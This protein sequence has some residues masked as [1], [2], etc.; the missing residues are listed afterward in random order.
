MG[1]CKHSITSEAQFSSNWDRIRLLPPLLLDIGYHLFSKLHIQRLKCI[2]R[3]LNRLS[4]KLLNSLELLHCTYQFC[5]NGILLFPY[6]YSGIRDPK[7]TMAVILTIKPAFYGHR[8]LDCPVSEQA[9]VSNNQRYDASVI[10]FSVPAFPG[11]IMVNINW[12]PWSRLDSV[13]KERKMLIQLETSYLFDQ[14]SPCQSCGGDE[15]P[16][17]LPCAELC[18]RLTETYLV[19]EK[20]ISVQHHQESQRAMYLVAKV[21]MSCELGLIHID[22]S[23]CHV[24]AAAPGVHHSQAI[25]M[26]IL[27]LTLVLTQTNGNLLNNLLCELGQLCREPE[28]AKCYFDESFVVPSLLISLVFSFSHPPIAYRTPGPSFDPLLKPFSKTLP[29]HIVLGLFQITN[30]PSHGEITH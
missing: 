28:F 6:V 9:E 24:S 20:M 21:A 1:N 12:W 13:L 27:G 15:L 17:D 8:R 19:Q 10:K 22:S 14:F 23:S 3:V 7:T 2:T 25:V 18:L 26:L 4:V 11:A 29:I 5:L 16:S 30:L